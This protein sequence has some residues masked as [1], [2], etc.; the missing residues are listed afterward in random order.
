MICY[1][2]GSG[3][4]YLASHDPREILSLSSTSKI[5]SVEIRWPSGSVDRVSNLP[6]NIYIK[7]KKGEGVIQST[8]CCAKKHAIFSSLSFQF[9]P[10]GRLGF[11]VLAGFS[12]AALEC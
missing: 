2:R 8:N 11:A 10:H 3:L 5:D 6:T 9:H 1:T 12:E 4:S 7:V